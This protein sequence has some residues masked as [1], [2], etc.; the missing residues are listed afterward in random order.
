MYSTILKQNHKYFCLF[1]VTTLKELST[2]SH[3]N[4]NIQNCMHNTTV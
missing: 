1:L 4:I 3:T 2:F